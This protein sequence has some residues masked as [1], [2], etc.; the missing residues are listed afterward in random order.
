MSKP[1][2]DGKTLAGWV[3]S[4]F[5]GEGDVKVANPF[6]EGRAAIVIEKGTTLSGITSTRRTELP[7]TNYELSFDA[8]RLGGLDF[9][10]ALTFPVDRSACT[11][12]VGGWGGSVVG[13]SSIDRQD[14]SQNETSQQMEFDDNRWYRIRVRVTGERIEAWIDDQKKIDV[15]TQGRRIGMR[16]GEIEKSRPLGFATYMTRAAFREITLRRL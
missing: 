12:V 9:F 3:K 13:L 5:E 1:L 16:P 14:A 4:G 6:R 10:C 15:S 11:L 8:M 7:R 2:F